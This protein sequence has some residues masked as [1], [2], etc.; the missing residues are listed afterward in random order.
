MPYAL[1]SQVLPRGGAPTMLTPAWF[2]K[3]LSQDHEVWRVLTTTNVGNVTRRQGVSDYQLS[4]ISG[5]QT[6][7]HW[8]W[9]RSQCV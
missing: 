8:F 2:G 5:V 9:H 7:S 6:F 1:G 3:S 4:P